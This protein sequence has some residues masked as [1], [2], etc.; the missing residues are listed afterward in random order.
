[1]QALPE[2]PDIVIERRVA[3]PM[4]DGVVLY[5]D[6]Y[7]PATGQWPVMLHRTPYGRVRW[8]GSFVQLSPVELAT[9]G[10]AVVVQDV[11]GRGE[12][13]GEH[14]PF[15]EAD[16][17]RA[18]VEWAACQPW[19]DGRVGGYGSS[20]MAASQMQAAVAGPAAL[21]VIAPV[22]APDDYFEGRT[23]WGGAFELGSMLSVAL[24]PQAGGTADRLPAEDAGP[25][26]RALAAGL[27]RLTDPVP[28]F[29]LREWAGDGVPALE[30]LAPWFFDWIRH[31]GDDEYWQR[32]NVAGRHKN[33]RAC[34][35]HITGWYDAFCA[36]AI[37]NFAGL[38]DSAATE[39]ARRGQYLIVGPWAHYS[40]AG[41]H[42]ARV[43]QGW[44]GAAA[45]LNLIQEQLDWFDEFFA[46]GPSPSRP[47]VRYFLMGAE[48][49]HTAEAW[50][51]P[52]ATTVALY[53]CGS[54]LRIERG[55]AG[56]RHF[57]YDPR[58]PVPT[59][60]GAQLIG[61]MCPPG[62]ADRRLIEARSDVLT[63]TGAEL[64]DDL[65]IAGWV[66]VDLDVSSSAPCTDFTATLVDVHP[67]GTAMSVCEG[68]R[69]WRPTA[70]RELVHIELGATAIRIPAGH[71][72]RLEVSSS[73]FPRFDP[74]PNTG[75][76][77]WDE[78][79]PVVARQSVWHGGTDGSRL[80][81][82]V[83]PVPVV[84]A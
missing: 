3:V 65:T 15:D 27:Q 52:E 73:N 19:S 39:Q 29:P 12:S 14:R 70:D 74:N 36:G 44:F 26:R 42:S 31:F 81:L 67:D 18:T 59:A 28:T 33:V 21:S 72:V 37:R 11:R 41:L 51:P 77:A 43:G 63:Y 32:I 69:R 9:H 76:L 34:G 66:N 13:P 8:I 7:R 2:I 4:A 83:L 40:Q 6:V 58:D 47:R 22:Q 50:P 30:Q 55:E 79:A 57:D 56:V 24:G 23:Y 64:T 78:D 62:P 20:Y 17:G 1:M 53:L 5:A 45:A 16:D 71:R 84:S 38:S 54:D 35:L 80:E 10:Y 68:I 49:W 46:A 48:Q 75:R 25:L 82:P 60:G 61:P